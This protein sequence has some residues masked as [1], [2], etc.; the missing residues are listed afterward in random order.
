[1]RG[2][3]TLGLFIFL[4]NISIYPQCGTDSVQDYDGNWYHTV[5]IGNQCW[6]KENMRVTHYEDGTEI[7]HVTGNTEWSDVTETDKAWCYYDNSDSLGNIYGA[8]YTWAAAMNGATSS[9]NN[10]SGVQGVCP[11]GWHLPSYNEWD[12]LVFFISNDG[13]TGNEGSVLKSL[14]GWNSGGNGTDDYG[15]SGLPGGCRYGI[16]AFYDVGDHGRWWSA[17]EHPTGRAWYRG[18]YYNDEGF[19]RSSFHKKTGLSVRCL[20]DSGLFD[21][22]TITLDSIR[23]ISKNEGDNGAV[24]ISVTG[25]LPPY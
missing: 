13:Y 23:N 24:Y 1:M 2:I 12:D 8:L 25:G 15:F 16:G 9:N 22:L 7:P 5:P 17:T 11:D 20:R 14:Y 3:L 6:M 10:P 19:R 18:L 21:N 4:L